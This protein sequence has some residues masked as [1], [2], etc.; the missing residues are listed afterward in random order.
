MR[1]NQNEYISTIS[2][3]LAWL[4]VRVK[5]GTKANLTDCSVLSEGFLKNFLNTLCGWNL[6]NLNSQTHNAWGA[7]LISDK[8]RIVIQVSATNTKRKLQNS[9][10]KIDIPRYSGYHFI[11]VVIGEKKKY[12]NLAPLS[13]ISFDENQDVWD[14]SHIIE[15]S[16][17]V[18]ITKL[19]SLAEMAT[20]YYGDV[21]SQTLHSVPFSNVTANNGINMADK[22]IGYC[23]NFGMNCCRRFEVRKGDI[24]YL[25]E[26]EPIAYGVT[27]SDSSLIKKTSDG[28]SKKAKKAFL[29]EI[30]NISNNRLNTILKS[31]RFVKVFADTEY[32]DIFSGKE[33]MDQFI[34]DYYQA[35]GYYFSILTPK[36][37]EDNMK[38]LFPNIAEGTAIIDICSTCVHV[39]LKKKQSFKT[40]LIKVSTSEI[41]DIAGDGSWTDDQIRDIKDI[42]RRK[43]GSTL[44]RQKA[45]T[46]YI[47]KDECSFMEKMGYPLTQEGG[48][49]H[50]GFDE[51]T[52]T[53]KM[54]LYSSN[55]FR[56]TIDSIYYDLDK[57]IREKYYGFKEGH[58]ILETIFELLDIEDVIPTDVP[59]ILRSPLA[60]IFNVVLSGSTK[61]EHRK[62]MLN[63]YNYFT[64]T[65]HATVTSPNIHS[66]DTKSQETYQRHIKAI[67]S[68]DLLFVC[69]G[70]GYIGEQTRCDIYGATVLSKPIAYW[71]NPT[72]I[73]F[74]PD[75]LNYSKYIPHDVFEG[76]LDQYYP[77]E[78]NQNSY[79]KGCIIGSFRK[80]YNGIVNAI[81]QFNAAGIEILSPKKSTIIN[82]EADFVR[83]AS[84]D[85]EKTE[86]EIQAQV[87]EH[88][89]HSDFVYVWNPDGYIGRTTC[90][91]IGRIIERGTPIFYKER[92]LDLPLD[93]PSNNILDLTEIIKMIIQA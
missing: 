92:P 49:K 80:H 46:A 87:F 64:K 31:G 54:V 93:V 4:T 43:I 27:L 83:L 90:Y 35:T 71:N 47:I 65:L 30:I 26:M 66:L 48:D 45:K 75:E 86:S 12:E 89:R 23:I 36:Q 7:D 13:Y 82:P 18:E 17:N 72:N 42:I 15:M 85:G 28:P 78:N 56:K 79:I 10:N 41:R 58:I 29:K 8:E 60:Y 88:E 25:K 5:N 2:D 21:E 70:D 51:Y 84:D 61:A 44:N 32:E 62:Y 67:K 34:D 1:H 37:T 69:N 63:A 6:D 81:E 53:N 52:K 33:E 77:K 50:I 20:K 14:T 16:E 73:F 24:I 19:K 74:S 40:R 9:L 59:N 91:E 11:F 57:N 22:C 3:V 38:T 76:L 68:C 39:V 55:D